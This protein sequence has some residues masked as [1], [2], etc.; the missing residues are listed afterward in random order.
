MKLQYERK[1][2]QEPRLHQRT[3]AYHDSVHAVV[4]DTLIVALRR[5]DVSAANDWDPYIVVV[6]RKIAQGRDAGFDVVPVCELAVSLLNE[7]A[8]PT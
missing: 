7:S 5:I 1:H 2:S 8:T 6:A 4:I 3:A